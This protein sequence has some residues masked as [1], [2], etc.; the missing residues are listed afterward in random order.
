MKL[1]SIVAGAPLIALFALSSSAFA[2]CQCSCV[3]GQPQALCS[4]A[5]DIRP[6]CSASICPIAPPSVAPINPVRVPPIGTTQCHMAQVLDPY[7]HQ[8]VWK[9][10]CG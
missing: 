6:F 10:I 2:A 7:T 1:R 4:S 5:L 9:Q 3:N 8:Y